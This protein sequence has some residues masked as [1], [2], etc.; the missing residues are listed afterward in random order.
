M[1]GSVKSTGQRFIS[2][3][4]QLLY[5]LYNDAD[6]MYSISVI[7]DGLMILLAM[8]TLN[9]FHPGFLL[10]QREDDHDPVP[11]HRIDVEGE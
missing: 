4:L 11:L 5:S 7:L 3:R 2:V 10:R 9:V 6:S 1:A 8:L